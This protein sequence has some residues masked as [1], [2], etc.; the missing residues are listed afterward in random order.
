MIF[1]LDIFGV[2]GYNN[3]MFTYTQTPRVYLDPTVISYLVAEPS[4]NPQLALWQSE[5]RRFW[6]EYQHQFAFVVSDTVLD[7]IRRGDAM[8]ARKRLAAVAQFTKL[9]T[10]PKVNALVQQLLAARAVPKSAEA[11]AEHIAIA[12]VHGVDYLVSWNHKHL[13]NENQLRQINRVCEAAG[14]RPVIICTPTTL[15]EAFI[16]KE[17]FVGKCYL[18]GFDPETY[19]DPVLEECY[20]IKREI[21]EE[22]ETY[23]ERR[24]Y[25]IALE[26]ENRKKGHKYAPIPPHLERYP[27]QEDVD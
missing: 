21:S 4:R 7:E 11:D 24:A 9:S 26:I 27:H 15:M 20:R 17:K 18:P 14:F 3:S 25:F 16:M 8:E 2:F 23:E 22:F 6:Q 5:S 1:L 10:T 12:T 13:V 19:T